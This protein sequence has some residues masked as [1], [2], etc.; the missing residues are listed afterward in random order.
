MQYCLREVIRNVFEHGETDSCTVLA[1]RY[2]DGIAEIAIIDEGIGI[3]S[4][5]SHSMPIATEDEALR[6]AMMPGVSR[7]THPQGGEWGN[8]GFGLYIISEL[9][10]ELGEFILASSGR[11]RCLRSRSPHIKSGELRLTG[12]AVKLVVNLEHADYFPNRLQSIVQRGEQEHQ[13]EHG[14]VKSASKRS[15]IPT[16]TSEL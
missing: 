8:S 10:R 2:A 15:T 7:V 4:S 16:T 5:L 6:L 14:V 12:T 3:H 13:L 1:Q 11:Y 9:G